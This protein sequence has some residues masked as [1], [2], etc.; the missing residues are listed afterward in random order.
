MAG[1]CG[2][3]GTGIEAAPFNL[4]SYRLPGW[5]EAAVNSAVIGGIGAVLSNIPA[6]VCVFM[7]NPLRG[8]RVDGPMG[9]GYLRG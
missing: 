8:L 1:A 2:A 5:R 4:D 7:D 3:I 6:R 9:C